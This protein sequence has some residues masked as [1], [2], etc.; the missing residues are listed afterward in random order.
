M[1]PSLSILSNIVRRFIMVIGVLIILL[2]ANHGSL[3]AADAEG[4]RESISLDG[5]GWHVWMDT[6]AVWKD[7]ALYAPGEFSLS[8]L[9]VNPPTGDWDVPLKSG[10]ACALPTCVEQVFANGAPEFRYHGVSWFVRSVE[11]PANWAHKPVFLDIART[12]LRV[13]VYINRK[14]AGYDL[15]MESPCSFDIGPFLKAGQPNEIAI[16][17]T[18]PGGSRG[19]NDTRLTK[20]G[21]K[22]LPSS[23]DFAGLDT[24]TLTAVTPVHLENVFVMNCLPAR[25]NRIQVIPTA[26][27][28]GKAPVNVELTAEILP[29]SGGE[30]LHKESWKGEIPA[31]G[32]KLASPI[33]SVPEAKQW[34]VGAPNLYKCRLTMRTEGQV[35]TVDTRFGFRVFEVKPR[36]DGKLCYYLNGERFRHRSAIDFGFYSHTGLSATEEEVHRSIEA[37][38]AIGHN[39]INL[40]RHIGEYRMLDAADEAGLALYEEPGGMH[41]WQGDNL[42]AGTLADKVIQE[43]IRRMAVRDRNHP[44]LLIH[45][46]SNEDNYW[47]EIRERA[48]RAVREINPGVM[49]CNASGHSAPVSAGIVPGRKGYGHDQASGPDHYMRPYETE[50]RDDYQ[51][52]HT[53]GSK[54]LFDEYVLQSHSRPT[55]NN[56]FYFGEVFCFTGPANWWLTTEQAA[57]TKGS[58]DAESFKLNHDKIAK[59]FTDW[60]LATIGSK[61]IHSP[62][63]ASRQA[64]RGLMYADGRLSQRIMSR[65]NVDGF[66]INGWSAHSYYCDEPWDSAIVDEGRNLKG[67]AEDYAFYT[68][69]VQ[70][71]LFRKSAKEVHPGDKALFEANLINEKKI[72]A[73]LYELLLQVTD[74]AGNKQPLGEKRQV[75]VLGGDHYAQP[76]DDITVPIGEDLHAGHITL[77]AE[78]LDADGHYVAQGSEQVI[79][80]NR[81]SWQKDLEHVAVSV[82]NWPTAEAALLDAHL[83][84]T[85]PDKATVILL[86]ASAESDP[87]VLDSLLKRVE[88]GATLV[89]HFDPGWA[90]TLHKLKILT[91]PVAQWGGEQSEALIGWLGNG[92]GYIDHFVGDQGLPS[93][94]T[95]SSNGWEVPGNPVGFY[96]FESKNKLGAYGLFFAR[97]DR[98]ARAFPD[99]ANPSL[100]VL[101]GTIEY[102]KGKI[103]L[104]PSY[105]VDAN[106]AFN[107]ML[108]YNL[109]AKSSKQEW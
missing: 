70:I 38:K 41:Q 35:D 52:D 71:A 26:A 101:L 97:P 67:P 43:K 24:V 80:Q 28:P 50:I 86:G 65:D 83:P 15:C 37:A 1:T 11:I 94:C 98:D 103:V 6:N 12:R 66:A 79:L 59:A 68:R 84:T 31:G 100:L 73:G 18:N 42:E 60:N 32:G 109:I 45:N 90:Q 27:N 61:Q 89:I 96:P 63:D 16:R 78:L 106:H 82:V 77:S 93:K 22:R 30:V 40:H 75:T 76:L 29:T 72:P 69:P 56:L 53:V 49:V 87:S 7:D 85:T 81:P 10:S 23:R 46:L 8:N 48:M 19:W 74:G 5:N 14:L 55:G 2:S 99:S 105:S 33:F 3:V 58:Y 102:G 88:A 13:E 44:S 20:W 92:W 95:L 57:E 104:A 39:G 21:D 108:F 62:A 25:E 34:G 17:L 107:D 91:K 54:A 9:P 64:G 4:Y 36:E 51:D 47:G